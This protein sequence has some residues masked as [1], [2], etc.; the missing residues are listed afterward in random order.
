VAKKARKATKPAAPKLIVR[1]SRDARFRLANSSAEETLDRL[2]SSD[3]SDL[4]PPRVLLVAAH[5][6]DE[7]IGAGALLQ[8]LP[9][10]TIVHV[11]D[12]APKDNR[13]AR[14][15]GFA[16]RD[17]YAAAR[18]REVV[19]ALKLAGIDESRIVGLSFMDGEATF[20]LVELSHKII[21][22]MLELDPEIVLTHPYEGGHTDHD[23][24]AFAVH[25]ACGILRREGLDAPPVIEFTSYHNRNGRRV[26]GTFLPF[27][28]AP[29]REMDLLEQDQ[30]LKLRMF[31]R[32]VSQRE[33]L[34]PFH[35][36][37]ERFRIAPR[38][39]FTAPPHE[40]QLDYERYCTTICG[41]EWRA[42]AGNALDLLRARRKS[43]A[44]SA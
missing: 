11:T 27:P 7:A 10:A 36:N 37:V 24:T 12:G 13:A 5:P 9:E 17:E 16:N 32:F 35:V 2:V 6:D 43:H 8:D 26:R 19:E 21:D 15:R 23:A 25:L 34:K 4:M 1:P 18:R 22:L 14:R 39:A 33:C 29:E 44:V 42:R 41:D 28:N 20:R 40:G 30:A 38:Y 31:S 3:T